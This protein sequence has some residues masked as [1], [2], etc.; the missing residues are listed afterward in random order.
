[1]LRQ[2]R[3]GPALTFD[4][5]TSGLA[6]HAN[7]HSCGAAFATWDPSDGRIWNWYVPYRHESGE[8]QLDFSLV[9]PAI[10]GLLEDET[11][12][13]VGHNLKFEDHF[14]RKEGWRV[15]GP[16]Y[17][18]MVAGHLYD[19]NMPLK[20]ET[21]AELLLGHTDAR[22]W[23]MEMKKEVLRLARAHKM[24]IRDYKNAHGYAQTPINLCGTY[25][26]FDTQHATELCLFYE[27][28]SLSSKFP[29]I[30]HTEMALTE[31][32][33]DMEENGLPVDIEY[34]ENLRDSL[35]GV[36]AGIE[37]Q[38]KSILGPDM[39]KLGSDDE[40]RH[41]MFQKMRLPLYKKTKGNKFS[42]DREVLGEFKEHSPVLKML[43]DWRD[44]EKLENTYTTSILK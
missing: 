23:E 12:L 36:K 4:Y 33:C 6:W 9:A 39:F 18:T 22:Y 8:K 7:A 44:A 13:K 16:R 43:L 28:R 1:M 41:F 26:C 25:A 17:D 40:L 38:I 29:R 20:L 19:E 14:S 34:L 11:K 37:D 3:A 42:V 21:R 27:R 31:A 32:L 15:L 2:L 5:E 30:W 10:K 35:G 24:G